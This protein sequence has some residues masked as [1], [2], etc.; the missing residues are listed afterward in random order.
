MFRKL[1]GKKTNVKKNMDAKCNVL[2]SL[3]STDDM[4][5]FTP[6]LYD[7]IFIFESKS[8]MDAIAERA[9]FKRS[10]FHFKNYNPNV[11]V[12]GEY[13]P[14]PEQPVTKKA[15]EKPAAVTPKQ[16]V[17][18]EQVQ[19]EVVLQPIR[20]EF[21]QEPY[22]D[23]KQRELAEGINEQNRELI[24]IAEVELE[25][26]IINT[27]DAVA[28][29]VEEVLPESVVE[30][31]PILITQTDSVARV[32]EVEPEPEETQPEPEPIVVAPVV[33]P[34]EEPEPEV[35]PLVELEPILIEA[36]PIVEA[37][38]EP[39]IEEEPEVI[40]L[41]E[42]EPILVEPEPVVEAEPEP[43]VCEEPIIEVAESVTEQQTAPFMAVLLDPSTEEDA[44][45]LK[46]RYKTVPLAKRLER[47]ADSVR[48]YYSVLKNELMSYQNVKSRM[49]KK[50]DTFSIGRF[51]VAKITVKNDVVKL[52]LALANDTIDTKYYTED[53]SDSE[54]YDQTPTLHNVKSK[55]G[56]KYGI[57]LISEIMTAIGYEKMEG[58]TPVDFAAEFAPVPV[59]ERKQYIL[60]LMRPAISV[61]ECDVITND[62]AYD[63]LDI[64]KSDA[65]TIN[66]FYPVVKYRMYT[67]DLAHWFNDGDKVTIEALIQKGVLPN[68]ENLFLEV[69]GR[70]TLDR[71]LFVEAHS[72]DMKAIK[73]ILLT[74]GEAVQYK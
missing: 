37:E 21:V 1:K 30:L 22:E 70:G 69:H 15:A 60:D 31:E 64:V 48:E 10:D 47:G 23:K 25:P 65:Y 67:D 62:L 28:E 50:F 71:K 17:L 55:R 18:A 35:I 7:D 6:N 34:E 63:M 20:D 46:Q 4:S 51:T 27:A 9:R 56:L 57:D 38:P 11:I 42:L 72:Y 53:V 36:E 73:M 2:G 12:E 26:I 59:R 44:E 39:V 45:L 52:Y 5:R 49:S 16:T 19:E 58:Y 54:I 40:P 24:P 3:Q 43:E 66:K 41:V 74:D 14:E 68:V 8:K 29:S 61:D 32:T 13:T 33:E